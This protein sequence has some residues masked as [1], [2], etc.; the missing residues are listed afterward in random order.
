[1]LPKLGFKDGVPAPV[2]LACKGTKSVP[3]LGCPGEG[4]RL[5]AK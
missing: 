3:R 1:V 4:V 5:T 2:V